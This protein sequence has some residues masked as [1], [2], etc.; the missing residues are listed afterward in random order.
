MSLHFVDITILDN[1]SP[2]D[3]IISATYQHNLQGDAYM[4]FTLLTDDELDTIS[5]ESKYFTPLANG[6]YY[7][8][9]AQYSYTDDDRLDDSWAIGGDYYFNKFSSIGAEGNDDFIALTAGH[10]FT[11]RFSVRAA[12]S[13]INEREVDD[14]WTVSANHQ[15]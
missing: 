14:T 6:A 10:F 4:G 8:L 2:L 1:D 15:F 11:E 5:L 12:Y 13:F 7:A 9:R 3:A